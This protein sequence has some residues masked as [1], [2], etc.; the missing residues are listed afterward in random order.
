MAEP[1]QP[2]SGVRAEADAIAREM[3]EL[4]QAEKSTALKGLAEKLH[5]LVRKRRPGQGNDTCP[6]CGSATPAVLPNPLARRGVWTPA[7]DGGWECAHPWHAE[8]ADT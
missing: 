1:E 8:Q 4:A 2:L 6:Q 5:A 3:L 7:A